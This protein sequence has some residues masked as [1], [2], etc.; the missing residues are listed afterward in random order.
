MNPIITCIK[1]PNH[2]SWDASE[3]ENQNRQHHWQRP[4]I[5]LSEGRY[6]HLWM[7]ARTSLFPSQSYSGSQAF[8]EG[9]SPVL[10]SATAVYVVSETYMQEVKQ[11]AK[12]KKIRV[13]SHS[14]Q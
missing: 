11:K 6:H 10:Q 5:Y 1:A 13:V 7:M 2:L 4:L 3:E 9:T 14:R 12:N 8:V